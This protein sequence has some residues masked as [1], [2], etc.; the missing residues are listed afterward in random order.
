MLRSDTESSLPGHLEL[1]GGAGGGQDQDLKTR[2]TTPRGSLI[3]GLVG[4]TGGRG[5]TVGRMKVRMKS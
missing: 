3:P 2:V 5:V 1:L 4:W